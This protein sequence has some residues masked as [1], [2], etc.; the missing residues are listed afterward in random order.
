MSMRI[1]LQVFL[2]LVDRVT[3]REIAFFAR[4]SITFKKID[5]TQNCSGVLLSLVKVM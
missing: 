5:R 3:C 2:L 1:L 4:E